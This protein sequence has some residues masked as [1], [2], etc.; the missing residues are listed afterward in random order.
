MGA[1]FDEILIAKERGIDDQ[2]ELLT[3][4]FGGEFVV[5]VDQNRV[6]RK[7]IGAKLVVAVDQGRVLGATMWANRVVDKRGVPRA[8]I[9]ANCTAVAPL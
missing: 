6:L 8:T 7:M 9:G 5:A 3:A 4:T 1:Q 2:G